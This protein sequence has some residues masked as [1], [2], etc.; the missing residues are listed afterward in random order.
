MYDT[1]TIEGTEKRKEA[2]VNRVIAATVF[3]VS[4][5][6]IPGATMGVCLSQNFQSIGVYNLIKPCYLL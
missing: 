4:Q 6:I 2:T 5:G 1:M 3:E